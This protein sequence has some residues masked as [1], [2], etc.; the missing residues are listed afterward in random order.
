MTTTLSGLRYG[1]FWVAVACSVIT[2]LAQ[3]QL[4]P[5]GE[6][7]GTAFVHTESSARAAMETA[8]VVLPTQVTGGAVFSGLLKDAPKTAQRK[9]PVVVFM[10]GS[11]G[12]GL[13]AIGE[14]QAWLATLGV[15]SIA[16][17][18]FSL[19]DRITYKSPVDKETY[20][21]IHQLRLSEVVLAVQAVKNQAWAD[22]ARM[23]LAGTSEG[24]VS[25]ARYTGSDFVGRIL[26][27]WSCENN[28]FVQEHRTA[29]PKDQPV[30]NVMS[31]TDVFFS[32]SNAW[33]GNTKPLGHCGD[34]LKDNKTASVTLI[35]GA[36][37][38]L[39]MLPAA[40]HATAGFVR[41]LLKP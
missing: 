27:S 15:A 23:V 5:G 32:S 24:A 17:N 9:V 18:S 12:L 29:L 31:A 2:C 7:K 28:Y 22:S 34:A 14:W 36:P 39:L 10:H 38:T 20:E 8:A 26:Y 11:S 21:K 41:D 40:Q 37:H 30:L 3:A 13:K 4:A 16:P 33:L 19:P 1:R 6:I 25:V 35:P